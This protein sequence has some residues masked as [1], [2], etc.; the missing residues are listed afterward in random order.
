MC[1]IFSVTKSFEEDLWIFLGKKIIIQIPAAGVTDY[2]ILFVL[3]N[4]SKTQGL[5][6]LNRDTNV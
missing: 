5:H 3:F 6:L 4:P 1:L 2:I